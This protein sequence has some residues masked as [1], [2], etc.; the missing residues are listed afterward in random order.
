MC[1]THNFHVVWCAS[2]VDFPRISVNSARNTQ[3]FPPRLLLANSKLI[4]GLDFTE[5]YIIVITTEPYCGSI[6]SCSRK[7]WQELNLA[8]GS[9]IAI[10]IILVDL[11]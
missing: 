1:N 7:Y 8:V 11:N 2:I 3:T 5:V 4:I 10:A 9:Q 6:L